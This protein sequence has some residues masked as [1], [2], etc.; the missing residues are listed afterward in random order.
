MNLETFERMESEV[1]SYCRS[2]PAVFEKASGAKL[3]D[4]DGSEYIDMFAGAGVLNYGHNEPRIKRALLDYLAEDNIVHALDMA[5]KPKAQ[6]LE[7]FDEII[8]RPRGMKYKVQFPGPTGTNAVEAALKLVRKVTGKELVIGFT[9][10]FHGMTL[11]S[12]SVTGNEMKRRGA[13]V[14]LHHTVSMPY[15]GFFG[16][17]VDTIQYLDGY[18]TA[19]GSGVDQLAAVIVETVQAEGGLHTASF[20]WLRRLASVCEEHGALL[21]V[22]DIQAGCG[23]TGTFFSF[24]R[25]GIE[26]DIIC[27]SKSLSG[28]GLPMAITLMKPEYDVWDPGEH[29]GTFRGYNSAFVTAVAAL[30]TFWQTDELTKEVDRKAEIIRSSLQSLVDEF[31][32]IEGTVRGRGMLQGVNSEVEGFASSVCA[33]AFKRGVVMETSGP[34]SEVFKLLPPLVIDDETLKNALAI[35]HESVRATVGTITREPALAAASAD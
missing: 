6:F 20:E 28:L 1:R 21:I 12:L 35:L 8:L 24:E 16:E 4:V 15:E 9:N 22:D 32:E 18:L 30:E 34:G 19:S 17:D 2:W 3:H 5:T 13:G 14:H 26:P 23:R 10:A 7:K 29:N 27:L 25:A 31:P 33:E 11:G